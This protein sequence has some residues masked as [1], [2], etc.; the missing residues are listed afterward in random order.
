MQIF[1]KKIVF[2]GSLTIAAILTWMAVFVIESDLEVVFFNVGEADAILIKKGSK[3][4]L[5]D[6]SRNNAILAKLGQEM[7]FWDRTIELVILTHP[8]A[9]HLG[10]LLHILQRYK[11]NLVLETGVLHDSKIYQIW[12][13]FD[14]P[15]KIALAGQQIK[16]APCIINILWPG[17]QREFSNLNNSSIVAR[18]ACPNKSFLFMGDA[19]FYVE[20]ELIQ[21]NFNLKSDVLK[22]GHHGKKNATSDSFL[23]AVLPEIAIITGKGDKEVLQKLENIIFYRTIDSD[24]RIK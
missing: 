9:D 19:E 11:I 2:L 10:G 18:M 15:R 5:I 7:P 24:V 16:F 6:G 21:N 22:L 1:S 14:V 8:H 12:Q 13:N 20:Q 4:I 3:Q 23:K 17:Q